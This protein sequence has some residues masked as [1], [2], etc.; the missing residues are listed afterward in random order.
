MSPKCASVERSG[1]CASRAQSPY[2]S[3]TEL[4]EREMNSSSSDFDPSNDEDSPA[5]TGGRARK[6]RARTKW[7]SGASRPLGNRRT[8]ANDRERHR[9]H[10][11]NSALD[12]LRS[13]LPTFP[14]DTKLTKIETLR[15]AHN[16]IWALTETLR[17]SDHTRPPAEPAEGVDAQSGSNREFQ[18]C[19]L[20]G[21][22][23]KCSKN[24]FS[25]QNLRHIEL[26]TQS[27][28]HICH[29]QRVYQHFPQKKQFLLWGVLHF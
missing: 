16:Y 17:I 1:T 25:T 20:D 29:I 3:T 19:P 21:D 11:L 12:A 2:G 13:V 24:H 10:N 22:T 26:L 4:S 18:N 23:T 27:L 8:K 14:D 6:T 7:S 15:F 5:S 9:M 28:I